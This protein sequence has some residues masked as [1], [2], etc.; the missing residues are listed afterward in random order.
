MTNFTAQFEGGHEKTEDWRSF[1]EKTTVKHGDGYKTVHLA[2]GLKKLSVTHLDSHIDLSVPEGC[3]AYHA[4]KSETTFVPG[5]TSR[6][7]VLG[8][9]VGIVKDRE[10]IEEY[11]LDGLNTVG[12][13]K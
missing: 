12:Y 1:S 4:I 7:R 10:V 5:G 8:K 6:T 2:K 13:R 9:I 11:F 3:E